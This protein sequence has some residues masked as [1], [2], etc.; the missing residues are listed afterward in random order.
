[1]ALTTHTPHWFVERGFTQA[2]VGSLPVRKQALYNLQRN[3]KVFVK[4]L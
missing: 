3:S 2:E 4:P 1:M